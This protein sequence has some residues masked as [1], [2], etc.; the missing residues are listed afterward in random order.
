[1]NA[2]TVLNKLDVQKQEGEKDQILRELNALLLTMPTST[3]KRARHYV[4]KAIG[5]IQNT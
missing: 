3:Q 2:S 1:M 4:Q 5:Y